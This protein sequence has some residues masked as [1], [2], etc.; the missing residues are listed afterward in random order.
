[1]EKASII[2]DLSEDDCIESYLSNDKYKNKIEVYNNRTGFDNLN[3]IDDKKAMETINRAYYLTQKSADL[4]ID[5]ITIILSYSNVRMTVEDETVTIEN[6]IVTKDKIVEILRN[7]VT[8]SKLFEN[9]I[10]IHVQ[11]CFFVLDDDKKLINPLNEKCSKLRTY[12]NIYFVK[13]EDFFKLDN[14]LKNMCH[15]DNYKFK[16]RLFEKR[17]ER[18]ELDINL[19][20]VEPIILSKFEKKSFFGKSLDDRKFVLKQVWKIICEKSSSKTKNN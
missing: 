8:N 20:L 13:K 6:G 11:S 15:F 16:A 2:I 10:A 4:D 17:D 9:Y 18:Y 14:V 3:I 5:N 7:M 1:M 12:G 19:K